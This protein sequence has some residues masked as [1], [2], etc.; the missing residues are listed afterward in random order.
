MNLGG[1]L[2]LRVLRRLALCAV[3]CQGGNKLRALFGQKDLMNVLIDHSVLRYC[4]SLSLS[5]L[6]RWV[7]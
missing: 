6:A 4:H 7:F 5:Q 3:K 1:G 2:I